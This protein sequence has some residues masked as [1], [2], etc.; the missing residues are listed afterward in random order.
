MGPYGD[1]PRAGLNDSRTGNL[2]GEGGSGR[3]GNRRCGRD[4][5]GALDRSTDSKEDPGNR[6]Q[7]ENIS[8]NHL[9]LLFMCRL[10]FDHC[11]LSIVHAGDPVGKVEDPV[12]MCDDDQGAICGKGLVPKNLHD[13]A[14]LERN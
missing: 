6:Q 1:V 7:G 9:D 13:H 8:A 2:V 4:W 14:N 10:G 12:V 5:F 11:D 3:F